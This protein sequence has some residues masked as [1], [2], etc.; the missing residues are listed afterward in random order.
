[1]TGFEF[2][3]IYYT[4]GIIFNPSVYTMINEASQ[5]FIQY[6]SQHGNKNIL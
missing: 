3:F 6:L 5:L 2:S 1:M 4:P